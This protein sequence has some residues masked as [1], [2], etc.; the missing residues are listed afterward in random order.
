M[1]PTLE[2][3]NWCCAVF[4]L[5]AVHF[6]FAYTTLYYITK[7]I[8]LPATQFKRGIFSATTAGNLKQKLLLKCAKDHDQN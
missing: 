3:K 1:F 2:I 8:E 7:M 5:T 6:P 4:Q